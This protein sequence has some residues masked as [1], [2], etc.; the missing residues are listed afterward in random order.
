MGQLR[1]GGH[2][3]PGLKLGVEGQQEGREASGYRCAGALGTRY[4]PVRSNRKAPRPGG[5][6]GGVI[7]VAV[8]SWDFKVRRMLLLSMYLIFWASKRTSWE[9][10]S[11]ADGFTCHLVGDRGVTPFFLTPEKCHSE[12]KEP[13]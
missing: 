4:Q 13:S 6:I 2:T 5:S 11:I 3:D 12:Q 9:L 1:S 10:E 8:E 7:I